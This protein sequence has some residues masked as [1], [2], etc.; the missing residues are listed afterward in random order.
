LE[1][2]RGNAGAVEQ[3]N[4]SVPGKRIA[5]RTQMGHGSTT[6]LTINRFARDNSRTVTRIRKKLLEALIGK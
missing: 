6:S 1:E 2:T 5:D 3:K 4:A